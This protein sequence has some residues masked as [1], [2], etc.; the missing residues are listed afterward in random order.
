MLKFRKNSTSPCFQDNKKQD[1]FKIQKIERCIRN[2]KPG[3]KIRMWCYKEDFGPAL[4]HGSVAK[5]KT[6]L[7]DSTETNENYEQTYNDN[8]DE[9]YVENYGE[10]DDKIDPLA[11]EFSVKNEI[12]DME[13]PETDIK[14]ESIEDDDPEYKVR[15]H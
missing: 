14:H 8:Y 5:I 10:D 3:V 7:P 13:S 4:I 15:V 11:E 2:G 6:E 12:P 9:N 1:S